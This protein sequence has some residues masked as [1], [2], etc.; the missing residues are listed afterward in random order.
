MET[1]QY[2]RQNVYTNSLNR[3][4]IQDLER[5]KI[6]LARI[7]EAYFF[8]IDGDRNVIKTGF[9]KAKVFEENRG[10]QVLVDLEGFG[11]AG[12]S[13]AGLDKICSFLADTQSLGS[14]LSVLKDRKV[15]SYNRGMELIGIG[16]DA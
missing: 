12:V 5:A 16:V 14:D 7:K 11:T 10:L 3:V 13:I 9:D 15:T 2:N 1:L 8:E 6:E 4:T